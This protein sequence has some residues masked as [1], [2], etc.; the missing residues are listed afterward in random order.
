MSAA[1]VTFA[2]IFVALAFFAIGLGAG[3]ALAPADSSV[4]KV[5]PTPI[6]DDSPGPPGVRQ[7]APGAPVPG[8]VLGPAV[9]IRQ[10]PR[11]EAKEPPAEPV[12]P[13]PKPP[14]P[15]APRAAEPAADKSPCYH[16]PCR[17]GL[18]RRR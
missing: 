3:T 13:L 1:R 18:F 11:P 6:P 8:P 15:T 2:L 10:L 7:V 5:A 9:P 4:E 16:T 17:R 14:A 12:A